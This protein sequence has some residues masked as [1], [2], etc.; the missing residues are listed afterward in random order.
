VGGGGHRYRW[1]VDRVDPTGDIVEERSPSC[2]AP[3]TPD[4]FGVVRDTRMDS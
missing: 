2:Q 1:P 3:T 4:R